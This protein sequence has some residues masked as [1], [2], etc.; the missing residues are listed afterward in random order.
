MGLGS[1][2]AKVGLGAAD[3]F[4]GGLASKIGD[5]IINKVTGAARD[6]APVLG[7]AAGASAQARNQRDQILQKNFTIN[8]GLPAN[9]LKTSIMASKAANFSPVK[10]NWGGPGSGLAGKTVSFTGGANNPDLINADTRAQANDVTH[11]EMLNQ[12]NKVQAPLPSPT[13]TGEK[14]LG[15]AAFGT[16]LTGALA[17]TLGKIFGGGTGPGG[18]ETNG[19]N[20]PFTFQP[21]DYGMGD[22]FGES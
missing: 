22:G 4:T 9:R 2:L 11:Q 15:G 7:G 18:Y 20:E 21:E 5:P 10:A 16:A 1:I 13:T 17:P 14:V 19:P 8:E 3:L 6:V 12:I